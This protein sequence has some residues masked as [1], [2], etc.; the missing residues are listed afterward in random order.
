MTLT[1][2]LSPSLVAA[3]TGLLLCPLPLAA[4]GKN[5][6]EYSAA[7]DR[8]AFKRDWTRYPAVVERST[9]A[10]VVALGDV[11]GGHARLVALLTKAGLIRAEA[12]ETAGYVWTGA[13]RVLVCTGD[14]IDKGDQSI[15]VLDLVMSL[16][17]QAAAAGGEVIV[18][19]GNHEA[20][21][22]AKPWRK[23]ATAFNVELNARGL[24]AKTV[25]ATGPYG[26]WMKNRPIAAL[27][28]GWFFAHGG[29]SAGQDMSQLGQRYREAVDAGAW[30]APFL[31]APDSILV[32]QKWWK[33]RAG[34]EA[35]LQALGASHIAFGHDPGAAKSASDG[36]RGVIREKYNGRIFAIDVG[37][38][39][40]IND[41]EGALLLIDRNG[42]DEVATSFDASGA[43]REMW[44]GR[45]FSS[46]GGATAARHPH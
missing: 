26:E 39:P 2:R 25:A 10:E 23:K 32:E 18:T 1:H 28:N 40:A 14:L 30:D 6:R 17:R 7:Q 44:R 38:S 41:G 9:S 35:S 20:E 19:L 33:D 37:M 34:V 29:D 12:S 4:Q 36:Q 43:R 5:R 31:L 21:F 8:A 46:S 13:N 3:L 45:A 24:D 27:V 22:L 16:E 42:A 11:H 15:P